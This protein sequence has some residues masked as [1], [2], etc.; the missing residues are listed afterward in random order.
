M[1]EEGEW[2]DRRHEMWKEALASTE[3][4]PEISRMESQPS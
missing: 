4:N 1:S 2:A 3:H